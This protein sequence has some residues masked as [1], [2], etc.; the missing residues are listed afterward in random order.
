MLHPELQP[1]R[2][3][4][5]WGRGDILFRRIELEKAR[6]ESENEEEIRPVSELPARFDFEGRN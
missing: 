6:T 2:E 5:E 1:S 4:K 3:E